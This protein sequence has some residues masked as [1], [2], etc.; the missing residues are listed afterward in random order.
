MLRIFTKRVFVASKESSLQRFLRSSANAEFTR[1]LNESDNQDEPNMDSSYPKDASQAARDY[2]KA[3]KINIADMHGKSIDG[4]EPVLSFESTPFDARLIRVFESQGYDAPTATQA[5]SWPI[6]L[7]KR[8][9][10]SVAK[11]GS[12]K[13]CGFLLP[14]IHNILQHSR[15]NTTA[16]SP[17]TERQGRRL[18]SSEQPKVLVLAPTRELTVQIA[19]ESEKYTK[20]TSLKT[21]CLFGGASR[22]PQI[23]L[24]RSG[25]DIVIGTP[26]RCNDLREAGFL[27]LS[28]VHYF[29]LDEADRM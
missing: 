15:K 19:A 7:D 27:N 24:L 22:E 4:Y 28:G 16:K 3:H 21:V 20:A 1:H 14:A 23:S 29:V 10:I 2:R 26:G 6:A 17:S 9:L 18:F 13:T 11:T 5:Q 12:G 8:D 25:C